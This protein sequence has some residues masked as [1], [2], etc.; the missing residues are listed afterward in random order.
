[1]EFGNND[2]PICR[3]TKEMQ[4]LRTDSQYGREK[5]GT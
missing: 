5:V 1:M 4:I 3:A 2:D